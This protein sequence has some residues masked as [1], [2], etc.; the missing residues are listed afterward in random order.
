MQLTGANSKVPRPLNVRIKVWWSLVPE[1]MCLGRRTTV[2]CLARANHIHPPLSRVPN[3]RMAVDLIAG[4]FHPQ[5]HSHFIP[6]LILACARG[7]H[8]THLLIR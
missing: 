3:T 2:W 6:I 1:P 5:P 8:V 4:P 7:A